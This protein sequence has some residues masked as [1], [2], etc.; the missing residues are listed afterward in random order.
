MINELT[1]EDINV[2]VERNKS[3]SWES[4]SAI[5]KAIAIR[6]VENYNPKD[7][8]E[9]LGISR[10]MVKRNLRDPLVS[11]YIAELQEKQLTSGIIKKDFI[12]Q[13]YL[14]LLDYAM[15]R[16]EYLASMPNGTVEMTRKV[17]MPDAINILREMGK[18]IG[19]TADETIGKKAPVSVTINLSGVFPEQ[20]VTIDG[21]LLGQET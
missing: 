5:Q 10:D 9:F 3:N 12:N 7:V 19:Y 21:E 20:G 8:A 15:G 14:T 13:H 2:L 11:A 4:L 6:Y 1:K 16:E 18:S 17:S